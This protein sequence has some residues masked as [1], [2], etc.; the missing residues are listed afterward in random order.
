MQNRRNFLRTALA[1]AAAA[2]VGR[3]GVRE[4]AAAGMK[5]GRRT[6]MIDFYCHFSAMRVIDHLEA[7]GGPKPHVFRSLFANTLTLIDPEQRLRLMDDFG[8]AR[9]VLVPL[10]WLET[11]PAVHADAAKTKIFRANALRLLKLG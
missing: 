9:S 8:V 7:A 3:A 10:P 6:D 4:I 1:S 11:A 2:V 5:A